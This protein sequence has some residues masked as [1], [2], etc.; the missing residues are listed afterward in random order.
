MYDF[1]STDIEYLKGVGPIR[2]QTLKKE[3]KIY[4]FGDLYYYFPFRYVDK[5]NFIKIGQIKDDQTYIVIS[6]KIVSVTEKG[7]G[8]NKRLSAVL[9]DDSGHIELI[10]FS[11]LKWIKDKIKV[12]TWLSAFGKPNFYKHEFSLAHPE[13]EIIEE[14]AQTNSSTPTLDP[15]YS[16]S[17]TMKN[18][19]LSTKALSILSQNLIVSSQGSV[20]EIIPKYILERYNL[21]GR[22]DALKEIHHPSNMDTMQKARLRLKFEELFILQVRILQNRLQNKKHKGFIF[23]DIGTLFLQFFNNNLPFDLTSAQKRVIKEIRQDTKTGLQMNRLL[24]GDVGSGK[25]IVAL[26]VMLIALDNGFQACIMAPTE[27]LAKQH[28]LSFTKSLKGLPIQCALLTGSTPRSERK[29][30]L[31]GLSQGDIQII[32]GTHALLENEVSFKNIGLAVIDEQHRFGVAQRAKLWAKNSTPPHILVMTATPIP[33]T[34]G[35]TLYGDLD[36]SVIN[37]LPPNRKPIQTLHFTE[38]LRL[39][40]LGFMKEEIK[41]GRQ[42]YVVYPLIKESENLDLIALENGIE[43]MLHDFP[44]PQ[45]AISIVHGQMKADLKEYEMNRF[46]KGE[47]QIMVSTTVI[48]VGVDVPNASVMIIEN[49]ERFGLSQ[50]HQLRGRVGRGAEKS[51]CILISG[52]NLSPDAKKRIDTMLSTQDGFKIAEVD[53][54][55][56]GPGDLDRKS[57]V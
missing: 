49:S 16:T 50:L 41:K 43:T 13:I 48:E 57:V 56:R 8:R 33:R 1:L 28:F 46:I 38:S 11:G 44:L 20:P 3:A 37:E 23:N 54:Q 2:A 34:L 30:I 51:F 22:E 53:L 19:G 45:Y 27:I 4:T 15:I 24:Q 10:W 39:R 36:I 47:T 55:L 6:G 26:M 14:K 31:E 52:N 17:E 12:G 32:I 42:I 5:S 29:V 18:K 40:L 21:I 35:M 25:T 9:K 7:V